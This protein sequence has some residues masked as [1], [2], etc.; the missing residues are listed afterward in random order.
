MAQIRRK[1]LKIVLLPNN[2]HPA[3]KCAPPGPRQQISKLLKGR[4]IMRVIISVLTQLTRHYLRLIA[5]TEKPKLL[6]NNWERKFRL[7]NTPVISPRLSLRSRLRLKKAS[8]P[9]STSHPSTEHSKSTRS[10]KSWRGFR[11]F[12]D[13]TKLGCRS[14]NWPSL[15]RHL[16]RR[17]TCRSNC[18]RQARPNGA[19]STSHVNAMETLPVLCHC[20]TTSKKCS[21][22]PTTTT[23]SPRSCRSTIPNSTPQLARK[24]TA[25]TILSRMLC[26]NSILSKS[27]AFSRVAR[28][29]A[30]PLQ[31][32]AW[33][34]A[35]NRQR[36]DAS[37]PKL[38]K[39]WAS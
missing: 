8:P 11:L 27:S 37:K 16:R 25:A 30:L 15:S 29:Q 14:P 5:R 10:S 28:R 2:C 12:A 6:N 38:S 19:W 24:A 7:N 39:R 18:T 4:P 13:S 3:T 9:S 20:T 35:S 36:R 34:K 23:T 32:T 1:T 21:I 22:K 31:T 17:W 26:F 33:C